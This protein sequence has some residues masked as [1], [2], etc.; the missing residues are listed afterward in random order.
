MVLEKRWY[1][2]VVDHEFSS[3][4][5]SKKK[6][7][8]V[9][10]DFDFVIETITYKATDDDFEVRVINS[11]Q[12]WSNDKID[13]L[14]FGGTVKK[15]NI[16]LE[17]AKVRKNTNIEIELTN[18]ATASNTIQI[19]LTGYLIR[20]MPLSNRMWYQYVAEDVAFTATGEQARRVLKIASDKNFII[21]KFIANA[22]A[23]DFTVDII[24]ANLKWTQNY[25]E[26]V[27]IFGTA[28]EPNILYTPIPVMANSTIIL[29]LVNGSTATNNIQLCL[30]GYLEHIGA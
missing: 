23:D 18:G 20:E 15:P 24:D 4:N 11:E 27:N 25:V 10:S 29:Q 30:E 5:A 6:L 13:A 7:L 19:C 1:Q 12:Q 17:P 22:T 14:N 3:A 16:L 28:Q 8:Q 2:Y 26:S 9:Q 21:Q